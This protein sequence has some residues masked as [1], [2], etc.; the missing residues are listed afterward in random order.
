MK[1]KNDPIART[2]QTQ[3][4][5]QLEIDARIHFVERVR[6]DVVELLAQLLLSASKSAATGASD[7][8]G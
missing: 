1:R 4:R 8:D 3:L 7:E 2:S 5:L 6:R